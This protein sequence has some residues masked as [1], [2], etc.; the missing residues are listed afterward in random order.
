M[1]RRLIEHSWDKHADWAQATMWSWLLFAVCEDLLPFFL[2]ERQMCNEALLV[3]A[4]LLGNPQIGD[5]KGTGG[6]VVNHV[7][8]AIALAARLVPELY[9]PLLGGKRLL[10]RDI[11]GCQEYFKPFFFR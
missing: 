3:A 6:I 5:D 2:K 11:R 4:Q 1:V 10:A 9:V 8:P 7:I